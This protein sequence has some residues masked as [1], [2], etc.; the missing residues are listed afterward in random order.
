MIII[1]IKIIKNLTTLLLLLYNYCSFHQIAMYDFN[2]KIG[3]YHNHNHKI[4]ITR[5]IGRNR[6]NRYLRVYNNKRNEIITSNDNLGGIN[7]N[8]NNLKITYLFI[9]K[10]D[11]ELLLGFI[12]FCINKAKKKKLKL[13]ELEINITINIYFYLLKSLRLIIIKIKYYNDNFILFNAIYFL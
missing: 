11:N 12:H 6:F 7:Y 1:E 10:T 5:E 8:N 2:N 9:N 13:I 3:I 4:L